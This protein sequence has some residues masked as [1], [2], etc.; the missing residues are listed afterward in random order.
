M[1]DVHTIVFMKRTNRLCLT[2]VNAFLDDDDNRGRW[3]NAL[4]SGNSLFEAAEH[5]RVTDVLRFIDAYSTT[6]LL[7]EKLNAK[8]NYGYTALLL[9]VESDI[10]RLLIERGAD[11]NV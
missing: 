4:I 5:V 7:Q 11:V 3:Q 6:G 8:N 1:T 10:V 9:A 2:R